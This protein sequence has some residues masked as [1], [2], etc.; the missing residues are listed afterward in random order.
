MYTSVVSCFPRIQ[1]LQHICITNRTTNR[2][3]KPKL[4]VLYSDKVQLL[5]PEKWR[6]TLKLYL[7]KR[8]RP[9]II[10]IHLKL[11]ISRLYG[12]RILR[13]NWACQ[14]FPPMCNS[15]KIVS[16]GIKSK[17][18]AELF[19]GDSL[20]GVSLAER[21]TDIFNETQGACGENKGVAQ[22]FNRC[23]ASRWFYT[24]AGQTKAS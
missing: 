17:L 6:D 20:Y 4:Q 19:E 22:Q 18:R 21:T 16:S 1:I 8:F 15:G 9:Y 12:A 10:Q 24:P 13:C 11:E 7:F 23:K 5:K 2:F 14:A 3:W